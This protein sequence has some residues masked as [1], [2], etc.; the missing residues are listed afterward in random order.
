MRR[1]IS[2]SPQDATKDKGLTKTLM[3]PNK[4][5]LKLNVYVESTVCMKVSL[6]LFLYLFQVLA[7]NDKP[8]VTAQ[9]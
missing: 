8:N 3:H 5:Q 9:K 6:G 7:E 4:R 1:Q 2:R